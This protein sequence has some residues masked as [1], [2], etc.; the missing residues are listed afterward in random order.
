MTGPKQLIEYL[1]L[2]KQQRNWTPS[3][4]RA[5]IAH[6]V[7]LAGSV[8]QQHR[9]DAGTAAYASSL[10]GFDALKQATSVLLLQ[11]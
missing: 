2:L 9:E 3:Q 10:L 11:P 7:P 6:Y 4:M 1:V 5:F 8:R